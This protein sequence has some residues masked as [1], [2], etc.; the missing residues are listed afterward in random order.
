M[1]QK[2]TTCEN[3][4][5]CY[6]KFWIWAGKKFQKER[7]QFNNCKYYVGGLKNWLKQFE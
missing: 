1:K 3:I 4:K 6:S 7:N 2:C 5:C